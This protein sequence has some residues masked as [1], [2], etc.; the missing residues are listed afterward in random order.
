MKTRIAFFLFM[1]I[2]L[3]I[4]GCGPS[5]NELN[6]YQEAR[7]YQQ[8]STV[9]EALVIR[10]RN[11]APFISASAFLVDKQKGRFASAKHFVGS[12]SDGQCKI[13]F[14]SRVY[15]GFLLKLPPITDLVVIQISGNFDPTTFPEPYKI[16]EQVNVGDQIFVRGIHPHPT[17]HQKGKE[18]LPIYRNYYDILGNNGEF[19]YDSL[20]GK[21]TNLNVLMQNK[22]IRGSSKILAEATN[23]F[24]Q[25]NTTEEH[26]LA[27]DRGFSGLSGGPTV[28]NRN[29]IVGINSNELPGGLEFRKGKIIQ[30]PWNTLFLVPASELK[31]LMAQLANTQ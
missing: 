11:G 6:I 7:R 12:E 21:I 22:T 5:A 13:F 29:E 24:T 2:F 18:I 4:Y 27:V 14:N 9:R 16:A 20:E 19:V 23:I 10:E 30:K 28:N 15:D 31:K 1:L 26:R 3:S 8:N 25:I 17:M